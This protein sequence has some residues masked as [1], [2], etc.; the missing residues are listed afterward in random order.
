MDRLALHLLAVDSDGGRHPVVVSGG[1]PTVEEVA[2]AVGRATGATGGAL[3][4]YL[5]EVRLDPRRRAAESGLAHGALLGVG[6]P[7]GEAVGPGASADVE[8]VV[9]GGLHA[10]RRAGLPRGRELAVGRSAEVDLQVPDPEV[11]RE[12]LTLRRADT[13]AAPTDDAAVEVVDTG[14]HNGVGLRGHRVGRGEQATLGEPLAIGASVLEARRP[15]ARA[16]VLEPLAED[17]TC[18]FNRP[19]RIL[20]PL[21]PPEVVLPTEPRE[22]TKRR[23]PVLAALIPAALGVVMLAVIG[24]S[25][26]LLFILLSPVLLAGN[27]WSDR[28]HGRK[29]HRAARAR[30]DVEMAQVEGRIAQAV[31][32]DERMRRRAF[33]DP[34]EV[35]ATALGPGPRLWERRVHDDDHLNLRVGT[36]D[37]PARVRVVGGDRSDHQAPPARTVPVV[38]DLAAAGVAGVAAGAR[39]VRT[40]VARALLAQVLAL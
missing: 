24:P 3:D 9:T 32:D 22:P 16:A 11:S 34:A 26:F 38:V 28:R 17:G 20:P 27:A 2:T 10:G 31:V 4:L 8:V 7:V 21:D 36:A 30:F 18:R 37:R 39:P 12:H 23:I 15:V 1:D 14:S 19:P 5:D 29:E 13:D 40:A 35:V 25:P 33:P 6:L